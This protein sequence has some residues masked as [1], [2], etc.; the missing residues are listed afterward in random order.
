MNFTPYFMGGYQS[1]REDYLK[2]CMDMLV[3]K[4]MELKQREF[5]LQLMYS[6]SLPRFNSFQ[7]PLQS[8]NSGRKRRRP[9]RRQR[10]KKQTITTPKQEQ[11]TT[12]IP[13]PPS[14]SLYPKLDFPLHAKY[15]PYHNV[16]GRVNTI[17]D[18]N[19]TYGDIRP[20]PVNRLYTCPIMDLDEKYIDGHVDE[21]FE[22]VFPPSRVLNQPV[23]KNEITPQVLEQPVTEN[24]M[25]PSC[26][27]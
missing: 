16:H 3:Q 13:P 10:V 26:D 5:E 24:T 27:K 23:T 2:R 19:D 21:L 1:I 17:E 15:Y 20:Y 6:Q 7:Y 9:R 18:R 12:P 8:E 14:L 4:D 22:N 25:Q 11:N